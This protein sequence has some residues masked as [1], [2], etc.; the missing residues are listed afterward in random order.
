MKRI[1]AVFFRGGSYISRGFPNSAEK[2]KKHLLHKPDQERA[3]KSQSSG[4]GNGYGAGEN[5]EGAQQ[6][7]IERLI[8]GLIAGPGQQV[9]AEGQL[10][11]ES[12]KSPKLFPGFWKTVLFRCASGG[13]FRVPEGRPQG[14]RRLRGKGL[15]TSWARAGSARCNSRAAAERLGCGDHRHLQGPAGQSI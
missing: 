8:N 7:G 11:Q 4:S 15:S 12:E 6:S 3:Q 13:H 9:C 1:D 5:T 2:G 14:N 10:G